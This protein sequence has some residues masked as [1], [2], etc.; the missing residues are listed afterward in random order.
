MFLK[1]MFKFLLNFVLLSED[2]LTRCF[3]PGIPIHGNLRNV[4]QNFRI[5]SVVEFEC[6]EGYVLVGD[7]IQECM[8]FLEWSGKGAPDCIG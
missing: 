5:G 4:T 2:N 6:D 3:H 8:Y 7:M 1:K